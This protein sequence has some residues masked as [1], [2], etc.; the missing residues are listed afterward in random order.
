[1]KAPIAVSIP[2]GGFKVA[3]EIREIWALSPRDA[4]LDG[5]PFTSRIYDFSDRATAQ[6]VMPYCRAVVD[7]N[8][9]PDDM[10]PEN[11]DG[12]IKSRT[13][14]G[15]PVYRSGKLPEP[16]RG[17]VLLEKYY[18]PYHRTLRRLLDR[19]DVRLGV[20]CH[21]MTA[22]ALPQDGDAGKP[23]PLVCL[24]NLGTENSDVCAPYHRL[25]TSPELVLFMRDEFTRVFQHE[26]VDLEVPAVASANVPCAGGHITRQMGDGV[27]PFVQIVISHAMYLVKPHFDS[28]ALEIDD[29][30][31][32]DLNCKIWQVLEKTVR[33]L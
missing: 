6:I 28:E 29:G 8:R 19:E 14:L 15:V 5:D 26:D 1:M 27:T 21:S 3:P 18:Y 16:E 31:V 10:P 12:V 30:R 22:V 32:R 24:G 23:R 2:H 9:A 11:P 33:N 7:L 4:F 25:T 20:D 17:K 13:R